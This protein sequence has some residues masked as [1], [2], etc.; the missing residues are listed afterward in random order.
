VTKQP[1]PLAALQSAI[2]HGKHDKDLD[3][4]VIRVLT[5]VVNRKKA[6]SE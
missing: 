4:I 6:L 1:S 3:E 5:S 2:L